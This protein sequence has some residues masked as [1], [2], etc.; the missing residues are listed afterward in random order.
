M[1]KGH[2]IIGIILFVLI[3]FIALAFYSLLTYE[4]D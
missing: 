1:K 2:K 4:V 3:C